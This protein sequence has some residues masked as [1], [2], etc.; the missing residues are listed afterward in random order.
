MFLI[1]KTDAD[2]HGRNA[3]EVFPARGF[4]AGKLGVGGEAGWARRLLELLLVELGVLDGGDVVRG[5]V[6]G[7]RGGDRG[8]WRTVGCEGTGGGCR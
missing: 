8:A 7:L 2:A 6:R 4:L 1:W 5:V 3:R